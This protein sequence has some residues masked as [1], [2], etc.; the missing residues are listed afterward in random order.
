M[1]KDKEKP[2]KDD[3]S[4]KP[5]AE[6]GAEP[7]KKKKK[8]IIIIAAA[9][10]LLLGGGG[11]AFFFLKKGAPKP[12]ESTEGGHEASAAGEEG[13]SKDG[14]SEN[15]GETKDASKGEEKADSKTEKAADKKEDTGKKEDKAAEGKTEAGKTAAGTD[16]KSADKPADPYK[17]TFGQIKEFKPFNV[18]LGNP[19]E[20][21]YARISIGIEYKSGEEQLAEINR[22]EPQL[23]DAVL[24]VVARKTREHL[25][26]PD[27]KDQL[28]LELRNR[29]NQLLD[30]KIESVF[31]TDM[32]IE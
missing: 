22:R 31:I 16:A 3:K 7:S 1:A 19:L 27:G 6:A 32:L 12:A 21:R 11:G 13:H 4:A 9:A 29:I 26:S 24:S 23:R 20:N 18:N 15:D 5:E 8:L 2:A 25:L 28:R 30:K 10:V 14:K 17:G